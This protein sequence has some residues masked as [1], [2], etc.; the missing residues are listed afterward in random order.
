MRN[1][2]RSTITSYFGSKT[3]ATKLL[4]NDIETLLSKV[5]GVLFHDGC[6][7]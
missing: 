2:H 7:F 6:R 4:S 3:Y 1:L 5:S